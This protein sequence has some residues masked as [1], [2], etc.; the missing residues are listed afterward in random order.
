MI[1]KVGI[2]GHTGRLGKPLVEMLQKHPFVDI[3]YTQ[4]RKEGSNGN[5]NDAEIVFLALPRGKSYQY[6]PLMQGK[7]IIDLSSDHRMVDDWVYGL[8]ELNKDA[9]KKADRIANPGCFP[10][11]II[12]GLAPIAS[13]I[14]NVC[15][16][17]TNGV[18]GTGLKVQQ[19]DNF[20]VF[21]EGRN[22]R[23]ITEIEWALHIN[24][25]LFVPQRIDT[26]YRGI[27]SIIF[28]DYS[29]PKD[30]AAL[31]THFYKKM[32]FVRIMNEYIN[33]KE[34]NKTNYCHIR[35]IIH[36]NKVIIISAIDNL[37]KGGSGQAVQ[38]F[39]IMYNFDETTGLW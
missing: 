34:V 5:L 6:L 37:Y 16:A 4:S 23:H 18:S 30:V 25:I 12:L 24:N 9:I 20:F 21:R 36:S 31:Y 28:A 14:S 29:G 27:V 15:I 26:A 10:T 39:N 13:Y 19:E 17:C 2:I 33:T 35:P 22:H 7:R 38:N 3:V 8:S 1:V 32:P 11:S